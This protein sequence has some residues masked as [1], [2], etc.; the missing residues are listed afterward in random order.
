[1]CCRITQ[2][3]WNTCGL[4]EVLC[5]GSVFFGRSLAWLLRWRGCFLSRVCLFEYCC[6]RLL[7]TASDCFC[8]LAVSVLRRFYSLIPFFLR[9]LICIC[10]FEKFCIVQCMRRVYIVSAFDTGWEMTN[11]ERA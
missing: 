9:L 3:L 1:M 7:S 6:L 2:L 8:S 11:N 4:E 10:E 5:Q